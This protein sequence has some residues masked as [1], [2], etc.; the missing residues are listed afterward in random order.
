MR[1]MVIVKA[2]ANSEAGVMPSEGLLTAMG[3]YNEELM[4]A[5]IMAGGEGLHPTGRAARV[6][7]ADGAR[8]VSQG[9]F[10]RTSDTIAG[11]WI[12]NVASMDEA[13]AWAKRCHDPMPGEQ[14]ELEIRQVFS[15]D[16]FGDAMTPELRAQ[17]D[18]MRE[19]LAQR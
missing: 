8:T 19:E 3:K 14:A 1:V 7:F 6:H 17:E 18:R 13:I 16:D 11:F 4:A 15:A 2:T 12:W 10:V 5:G 9:P